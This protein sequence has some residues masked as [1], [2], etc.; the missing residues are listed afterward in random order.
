MKMLESPSKLVSPCTPIAAIA[1]SLL[2]IKALV[3]YDPS[4]DSWYYHLPYAGRL[5]GIVPAASYRM[6][7]DLEAYY[8]GFPK[9]G[10]WLQGLLWAA[11]GRLRAANLVGLLSLVLYALFLRLRFG[12]PFGWSVL[13][14][15]AI[16]LVQ[17]HATSCYVDLP[18]N[19][20]VAAL[21]MLTC[22]LFQ[23]ISLDARRDLLPLIPAALIAAHY[24]FQLVLAVAALLLI[25]L[26]RVAWLR[27]AVPPAGPRGPGKITHWWAIAALAALLI[28]A[29][30]IKNS[31]LHGNPFYPIR[32]ALGPL[33]LNHRIPFHDTSPD[34]LRDAMQPERWMASLLEID[35]PL[36]SWQ[37]GQLA[38]PLGSPANRMGGFFGAYVVA[39]LAFLLVLGIGR[40]GSP[41]FTD[42]AIPC[43]A[44]ISA[45]VSWLPLSHELRYYMFWMIVLVSINLTLLRRNA[46]SRAMRL[47]IPTTNAAALIAVILLTRGFYALPQGITLDKLPAY[48]KKLEPFPQ[49]PAG[50]DR[51]VLER[52]RPGDE[53]CIAAQQP[54]TYLYASYFHPPMTYRIAAVMDEDECK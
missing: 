17:I 39:Q 5:W 3:D 19:L 43:F 18:G 30:P 50:I 49:V 27:R 36:G 46:D 20:A 32:V 45:I 52:L 8:L 26:T 51:R 54:I 35:R 14:L 13:S 11:T 4:W 44:L 1:L 38:L 2:S 24:K 23:R 21:A 28:F 48:I 31:L 34:H 16:P 33:V 22:Q 9:L 47:V 7:R 37:V 6:E 25:A 40:R 10:E 29:V 12:V 42:A 53:A 41:A 15:L